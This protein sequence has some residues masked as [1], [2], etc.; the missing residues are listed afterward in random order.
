MLAAPERHYTF[1][2]LR[3]LPRPGVPIVS[4]GSASHTLGLMVLARLD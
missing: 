3:C 1:A 2:V 4:A